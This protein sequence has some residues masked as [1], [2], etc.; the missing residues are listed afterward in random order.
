MFVCWFPP[1]F[2][3]YDTLFFSDNKP[4]PIKLISLETNQRSEYLN[5]AFS[6]LRSTLQQ[7]ID[8][9]IVLIWPIKRAFKLDMDVSANTLNA[10][11]WL[12]SI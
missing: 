9:G 12:L 6:H 7:L 10:G 8:F 4:A 11:L 3:S 1:N 2:I 5:R